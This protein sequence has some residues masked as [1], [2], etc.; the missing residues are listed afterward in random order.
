MSEVQKNTSSESVSK[1]EDIIQDE[2]EELRQDILSLKEQI[3]RLE[4]KFTK[5]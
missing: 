4:E 5:R 1:I 2:K 3:I